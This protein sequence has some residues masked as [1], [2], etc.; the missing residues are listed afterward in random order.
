MKKRVFLDSMYVDKFRE[1][2]LL[3]ECLCRL[4][5]PAACIAEHIYTKSQRM[6]T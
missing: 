3:L 2:R 4:M 6:I 1:E 5:L